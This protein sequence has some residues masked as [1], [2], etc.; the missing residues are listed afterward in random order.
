MHTC[1]CVQVAVLAAAAL[2]LLRMLPRMRPHTPPALRASDVKPLADTPAA[3]HGPAVGPAAAAV[4]SSAGHLPE[5]GVLHSLLLAV[6]A[7]L[8]LGVCSTAAAGAT[9][10]APPESLPLSASLPLPAGSLGFPMQ[11]GPGLLVVAAYAVLMG[12][13]ALAGCRCA[14]AGPA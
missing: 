6:E 13:Q 12:V 10:W 8:L 2:N 4:Q 7:G 3:A 9:G 14:A 1:A 5:V 11:P